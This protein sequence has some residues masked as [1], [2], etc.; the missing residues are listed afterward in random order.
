MKGLVG[1][2]KICG[3]IYPSSLENDRYGE[4]KGDLEKESERKR[5]EKGKKR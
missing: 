5:E 3:E 2:L 1:I 4:S